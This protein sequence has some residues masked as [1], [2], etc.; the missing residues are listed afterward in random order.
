MKYFFR[1]TSFTLNNT[2][3]TKNSQRI[4]PTADNILKLIYYDIYIF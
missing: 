1:E 4:S 3:G 2:Q